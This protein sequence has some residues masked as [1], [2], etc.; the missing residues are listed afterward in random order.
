[1]NLKGCKK[2]NWKRRLTVG[3]EFNKLERGGKKGIR[4]LL[5]ILFRP[6]AKADVQK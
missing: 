6:T 4:I 5:R 1:M 2:R 3:S